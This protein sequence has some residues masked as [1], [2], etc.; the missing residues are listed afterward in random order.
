MPTCDTLL[1]TGC[2]G[3]VV[4][5]FAGGAG[6]EVFSARRD[7]ALMVAAFFAAGLRIG[8]LGR[9]EVVGSSFLGGFEAK[10]STRLV[11]SLLRLYSH[12]RQ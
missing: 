3:V 4:L 6:E 9:G 8:D 5:G 1:P 11:I 10:K 7:L 2:T 12:V